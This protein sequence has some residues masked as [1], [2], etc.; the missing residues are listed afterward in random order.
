MF[1]DS[2][3][4]S[5]SYASLLEWRL[6]AGGLEVVATGGWTSTQLLSSLR[7]TPPDVDESVVLIGSNDVLNG[8]AA[9]AI[10]ANLTAL[11]AALPNAHFVTIPPCGNYA[12]W[13]AGKE[14][15]RQAVNT[16]I[17]ANLPGYTD[18]ELVLGDGDP[19]QPVL[20]AQY[21]SGDGLHPNGDGD[22]ALSEAIFAQSF[23][24]VAL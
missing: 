21:D 24:S 16:W 10:E 23:A 8:V 7:A 15:V 14:T 20:L 5:P 4:T 19:S 13:T 22:I 17:K 9:A 11:N 18:I 12:G 6:N 1:G 3:T 2:L